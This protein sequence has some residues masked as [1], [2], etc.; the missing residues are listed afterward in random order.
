MYI[1]NSNNSTHFIFDLKSNKFNPP[2]EQDDERIIFRTEDTS[3]S[4]ETRY[5]DDVTFLNELGEP[6][7]ITD[8]K[9]LVKMNESVNIHARQYNKTDYE[10]FSV[11]S[12]LTIEVRD[13]TRE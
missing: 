10:S 6:T 13:V 8:I 4:L 2:I 1:S 7:N 9:R 5:V 12:E 3:I 11:N